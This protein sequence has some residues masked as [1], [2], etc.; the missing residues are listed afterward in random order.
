MIVQLVVVILVCF[1]VASL[2]LII[3]GLSLSVFARILKRAD[4]SHE[5]QRL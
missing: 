5:E 3:A 2:A 4:S 1:F